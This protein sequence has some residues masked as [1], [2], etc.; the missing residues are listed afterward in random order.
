[1]GFF[2]PELQGQFDW[3]FGK[4]TAWLEGGGIDSPELSTLQG[5]G[6][7]MFLGETI[8]LL[9]YVKDEVA[10]IP[11]VKQEV[12]NAIMAEV[13]E[14]TDDGVFAEIAAYKIAIGGHKI[15]I[16]LNYGGKNMRLGVMDRDQY[17]VWWN[18]LER[19]I[20]A[21]IRGKPTWVGTEV[22][23]EIF[24]M[25]KDVVWD[26]VESTGVGW[27]STLWKAFQRFWERN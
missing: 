9:P 6:S 25:A 12:T 2:P 27:I 22:I 11:Q 23:D 26:L 13:G 16:M 24:D 1:M 7:G 3:D 19:R 15:A 21:R 8:T 14:Y 18:A 17:Y 10:I 5:D 20:R 4:Y